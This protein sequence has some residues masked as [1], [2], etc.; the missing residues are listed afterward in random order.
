MPKEFNDSPK[1]SG[2]SQFRLLL[3]RRFGPY[4]LTQLLG[5]FN[6][7][8]VKNAMIVFIT[9]SSAASWGM[10]AST[11]IN[12]SAALFILPVF[13]FSATFGQVSDKYEKSRLIRAVKLFE[14]AIMFGAALGFLLQSVPVLLA[15]LFLM[16]TQSSLFGPVKYSILP[17]HLRADELVGGNGLV[18]MGTFLA[19]LI[20]TVAGALFVAMEGVGRWVVSVVML[21]AAAL[22]YLTSRYIPQAD[23]PAPDLRINWN[24]ITET[25]RNLAFMARYRTVFL[26]VLGIS[27][28]WFL[29]ATYLTQL[30]VYAR[31]SLG[32]DEQ[33]VVLLLT[34]FCA[35]VGAGSLLCER[36][37][38]HM[39]ELGLVPFGAIGLT[40]FGV[41]LY[42]A[43]WDVP[44]GDL[45]G[46][47]AFLAQPGSW[48]IAADVALQ[49]LFGGFYIVPLYALIQ[50]RSPPE[51]RSRIIAGN[52]VLNALFMVL[53]G[54][55]AM[56]LHATEVQT[57][58][59][60]LFAA[61]LNALVAIYIF[62]LVPEFL[63]RF[64]VWM[65]VHI[66]YRIEKRG[67]EHIPAHG[68]ALLICNH[69]SFMDALIIAGCCRRPIRFVM[70]YSIFKIPVLNFIF[71][72]AGAIAISPARENKVML[73]GAYD[74][75]AEALSDG[76]LVCIFPEGQITHDGQLN[77]FRSGIQRIVR[78]TP[79][80]VVPMALQ[81]LWGS[82]FSRCHGRAMMKIPRRFFS[83]IGI[84]VGEPVPAN[85]VTAAGLREQV[86]RLRGSWL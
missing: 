43:R 54:L 48:R 81:G 33:V 55:T 35:G 28:F 30:P 29:G 14:I 36:M 9:F 7:N 67:M 21:L 52:N 84:V 37:S 71:R 25:W 24:P 4:F 27:W 26:S 79:V 69:V 70:H 61:G 31:S 5:A 41:D 34:L 42:L 39:V 62:S 85:L 64:L 38:G 63:M 86:L 32:A 49:G 51:H 16:G 53:S 73:Q 58:T 66:M 15:T 56:G 45:M 76:E 78:R 11:L 74:R 60:L 13:L 44:P 82:F 47:A 50:Q 65:L 3:E 6:D 1:G 18:E 77:A 75:V 57:P 22:G 8:M 23:P 59:L 80:P 68:P 20:G 2:R 46:A 83:R 17:Q 40:L 10:D 12:L 19:I 72:T